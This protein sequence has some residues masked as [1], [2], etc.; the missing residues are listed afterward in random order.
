M[1]L[2]VS[3]PYG[4]MDDMKYITIDGDDIG[5]KITT[6][7]LS[8]ST[9]ELVRVNNLVQEK[10]KS[11]A[12]YLKLEGFDIHFCAADGVAASIGRDFDVGEVFDKIMEIAGSEITFS[13]GVGSSLRDA[14]IAILYAKSSGKNKLCNFRDIN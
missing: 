14:Y 5:Q 13:A 10:T 12:Q 7:Y 3:P 8:N 2:S 9:A 6:A 11:I 1:L 4:S